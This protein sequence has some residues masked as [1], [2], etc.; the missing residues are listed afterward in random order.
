MTCPLAALAAGLILVMHAAPAVAVEVPRPGP[1]DPR[2]KVVDYD[3]QQ[4]VRIVGV[5]RTAT[6]ILFSPDETILHVALGDTSG[7]EVAPEGNVL[8][9]KP[10]TLRAPTNLIVTTRSSSGLTRHYTFEL[11]TR[12]GGTSRAAPDTFFVVQFRYPDAEK[13]ALQQA[14]SAEARALE[15]RIVQLK[16]DRGVLEGPR[17]LAYDLQGST[18]IAPSEVTDNGRFTVLRFPGAQ[19]MP[20]VY[21]VSPDG[22]ESLVPFDVRGEFLVVHQ[23]AA[24]LRLRK[25]R[26]VVCVFNTAY[27]PAG[28]PSGTATASPDVDRTTPEGPRP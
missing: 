21:A 25:G 15:A 28:A 27:R 7:W 20:A 2:I 19:A 9:A 18:A 24:Q 6:Q 26:E 11:A 16:L 17:N 4:V 5:F 14:L 23:I 1:A 13:A 10:K 12:A 3:P 8:F 22:S